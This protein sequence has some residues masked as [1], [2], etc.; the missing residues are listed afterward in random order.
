MNKLGIAVISMMRT[1]SAMMLGPRAL[2]RVFIFMIT[3]LSIVFLTRF[4]CY[5][6]R[7]IRLVCGQLLTL[8]EIKEDLPSHSLKLLGESKWTFITRE[9]H[10]HFSRPWFTLH[11][12][13]TSDCMKLLLEGV[14]N[15]DQHVQYLPAW[16]S[17]VGQAV[18][19]KIPLELYASGLKTQ[20]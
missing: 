4:Q 11:P 5:T 9:E 14:E 2:V 10:P 18:G 3:M 12:C 8:D 1:L 7:V 19:L 15:K 20:E 6:F 13:G 16:L 17:V